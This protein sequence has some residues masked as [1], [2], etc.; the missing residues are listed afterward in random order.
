[1]ASGAIERALL[2][3]QWGPKYYPPGTTAFQFSFSTGDAV[4]EMLPEAS[5]LSVNQAPV[6]ELVRLLLAIHL[7][8]QQAHQV[9][10][11][12]VDWRSPQP[13]DTLSLFDQFYLSRTPS[14]RAPHTSF[15]EIEELLLIEGM[16]PEL[17]HGTFERDPQ[18]RL[19]QRYALKDCLSVYASSGSV[20]INAAPPPV[21]A[22]IG[23]SDETIAAVVQAR[24]LQPFRTHEQLAAMGLTG[25]PASARL[26]IG[27][28]SLITV[29]ATARLR[30]PDGKPSELRRS[31]A[32]LVKWIGFD[33]PPYRIIR[34][35]DRTWV[36]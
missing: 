28:E 14:F 20:D 22:A 24:S 32:A 1:L 9:A 23:L 21:L 29:R 35:Y 19:V 17:F 12:I 34:W 31:V 10:Q 13:P 8:P 33:E 16:T 26:G 4:V 27:G 11:G 30:L 6:E 36:N 2:Y 7:E 15:Q 3:R 5:K 18:G 25:D